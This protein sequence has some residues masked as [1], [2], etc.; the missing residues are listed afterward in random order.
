MILRPSVLTQ[1]LSGGLLVTQPKSTLSVT[2][3]LRAKVW[4]RGL[5][6]S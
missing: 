3:T 1:A 5:F 6:M 2:I 4:R